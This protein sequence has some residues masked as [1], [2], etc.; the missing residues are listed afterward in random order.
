[1][2]Q[3]TAMKKIYSKP[4]VKVNDIQVASLFAV[5]MFDSDADPTKPALT[6]DRRGQWG[7]LWNEPEE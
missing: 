3:A 5:S 1:M 2:K 6:R 7:N 4:I